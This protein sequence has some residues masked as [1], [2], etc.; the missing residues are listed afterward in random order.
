VDG[1]LDRMQAVN[2]PAELRPR[3]LDREQFI[4]RDV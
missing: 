1:L 2:P 3:M 4:N